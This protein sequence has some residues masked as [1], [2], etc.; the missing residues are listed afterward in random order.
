MTLLSAFARCGGDE[1]NVLQSDPQA[2]VTRTRNGLAAWQISALPA[3][4]IGYARNTDPEYV[5]NPPN[6]VA[7]TNESY[8]G[9][10]I[11]DSFREADDFADPAVLGITEWRYKGDTGEIMDTTVLIRDSFIVDSTFSEAEKQSVYTHELGHAFGLIHSSLLADIMYPTTAG[12]NTP[13]SAELA[14]IDDAYDPLD[15]SISSTTKDRFYVPEN[16]TTPTMH[17]TLPTFVIYHPDMGHIGAEVEMPAGEPIKGTVIT[18]RH[19]LY[20]DGSE[21]TEIMTEY[22]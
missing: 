18:V 15:G 6:W 11:P 16:W 14:A 22:R 7:V 8:V 21:K 2:H 10:G 17:R 20:R 3:S 12:S 4:A 5:Y 13:S 19:Y 1:S 9:E